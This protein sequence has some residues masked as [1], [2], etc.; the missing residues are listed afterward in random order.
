MIFRYFIIQNAEFGFTV[1]GKV[2]MRIVNLLYWFFF[3][4]LFS[5]SSAFMPVA[6]IISDSENYPEKL[7]FGK[8]CLH[9][10]F[11]QKSFNEIIS[12]DRLWGFAFPIIYF[13]FVLFWSMKNKN[14]VKDVCIA[15]KT[16]ACFGGTY[17]RNLQT[18][19]ESVFLSLYWCVFIVLENIIVIII[20]AF[21]DQV[22]E[23]TVFILYNC[24]FFFFGDLF[25]GL[26]LPLKYIILSRRDYFVLWSSNNSEDSSPSDET[27]RS[28]PEE[29]IP[30]REFLNLNTVSVKMAR[31]QPRQKIITISVIE[32]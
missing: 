24:F 14:L 29:K 1:D 6:D 5:V 25:H 4:F 19:E 16:F 10:T 7:V 31:R 8:I 30:R 11:P 15:R 2:D 21:H 28:D 27:R 32:V 22:S 3:L 9:Q 18:F 26:I 17:R 23:Q 13:S 20:E 12:R